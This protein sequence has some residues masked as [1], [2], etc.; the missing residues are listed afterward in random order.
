MAASQSE[1]NTAIS[2]ALETES[3]LS[4]EIQATQTQIA[5]LMQQLAVYTSKMESADMGS[6]KTV[7]T[8]AVK[9]VFALAVSGGVASVGTLAAAVFAVGVDLTEEI[10]YSDRIAA[11][12]SQI[13]ADLEQL[14]QEE[15]QLAFTQAVVTSLQSVLDANTS[16]L[17]T[18][19]DLTT[20]WAQVVDDLTWLLIV[21]SM[22]QIDITKVP[23]L[24]DLADANG[25]WQSISSFAAEAQSTS[26]TNSSITLPQ[27][28]VDS[29]EAA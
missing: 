10:I 16:A 17:E 21:L 22:P 2:G 27:A 4:A 3:E 19:T 1:I 23:D 12:V 28:T 11:L 13:S 5:S 7:S 18:F 26:L 20:I 25:S 15:V 9:M 29:A 24:L 14:G 8:L 6:V